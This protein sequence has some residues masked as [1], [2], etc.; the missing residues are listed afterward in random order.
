MLLALLT[1]TA[2][3]VAPPSCG[4]DETLLVGAMLGLWSA[5]DAAC[6]EARLDG[7]DFVEGE[8]IW[9]L[10]L[11]DARARGEHRRWRRLLDQRD[12]WR[13]VMLTTASVAPE[14]VAEVPLELLDCADVEVYLSRGHAC[15]VQAKAREFA[16]RWGSLELAVTRT[17]PECQAL[18]SLAPRAARGELSDAE[19]ACLVGRAGTARQRDEVLKVVA[20]LADDARARGGPRGLQRAME[21]GRF[22]VDC[23]KASVYLEHEALCDV[24]SG[25]PGSDIQ[26]R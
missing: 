1:A 11:V 13:G 9:R 5:E 25:E 26:G 12:L 24:L 15:H 17:G 8:S 21:P 3:A 20:V 18:A 23:A 16:S 4:S 19:R 10:L 7:A 22:G 2:L 6:M 14:P